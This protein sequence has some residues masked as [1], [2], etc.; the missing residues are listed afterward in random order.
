MKIAPR[1]YVVPQGARVQLRRRPTRITP[2]YR[3]RDD[4]QAL[5]ERHVAKMSRLQD[6]LYAST[7]YA[8][9][10]IFQ[11]MDTAG[12]DGVIRHVMRGVNPLGC[13]AHSFR[14]PSATEVLHDFLWRGVRDLPERGRLGLFNRS[15][16]EEVVVV[17]VHPE[18]LLAQRFP[19]EAQ[20]DKKIWPARYR[21]IVNF[22]NH[23]FRNGTRVV[24][25]FLHLSRDEQRKRLL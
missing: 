15:Y 18:L 3:D 5:L 14:R 17:R 1:D 4:Y 7:Q 19:E 23:L 12:K 20:K 21:S 8:V 24:K 16:Y 9:L 2:L 6:L 25:F 11:G 13:Q 10:L 22:E